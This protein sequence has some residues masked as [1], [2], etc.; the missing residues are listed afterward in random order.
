VEIK[1]IPTLYKGIQFR[2]RLEA[3]WAAFFDLLRWRWEYE[4]FD[5]DGWIPDF[6]LKGNGGRPVLVEV[7]PVVEEPDADRFMDEIDRDYPCPRIDDDPSDSD[8]YEVLLVGTSLLDDDRV[9]A[10]GW[11]REGGWWEEAPFGCWS[12][13]E[14][15]AKN[16]DGLIGF[17]HGSGSYHDRITG[18]YDGGHIGFGW[19]SPVPGAIR[20]LWTEAGNVVPPRLVAASPTMA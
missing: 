5:L 1:A 2:S 20:G 7:K 9:F 8:Q 18:C 11:I 13:S 16:P 4:P 19:S 15:K 3:R 17:C 6:I 12:G 10:I 14:S